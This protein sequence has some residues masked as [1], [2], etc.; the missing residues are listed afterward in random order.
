[1][2]IHPALFMPR[3]AEAASAVEGEGNLTDESF[4]F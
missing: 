4:L 3:A 1:M 2:H